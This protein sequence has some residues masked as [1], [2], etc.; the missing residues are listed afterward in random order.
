MRRWEASYAKER[1]L[2]SF[3]GGVILRNNGPLT[4]TK[5]FLNVFTIIAQTVKGYI[6]VHL[7]L[8]CALAN[9]HHS[10]RNEVIVFEQWC[11]L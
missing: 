8:V 7:K 4:N 5:M 10:M 6:I 9:I 3:G 11:H 1:D 2:T